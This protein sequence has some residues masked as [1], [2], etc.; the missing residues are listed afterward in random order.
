[1]LRRCEKALKRV[2]EFQ[3]D[4]KSDERELTLAY[5]SMLVLLPFWGF[6][7]GIIAVTLTACLM[8]LSFP[9]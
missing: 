2:A 3:L 4:D 6:C 5:A 1:M 7:S 8:Q 9:N